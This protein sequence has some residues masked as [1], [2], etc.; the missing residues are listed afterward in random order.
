MEEKRK[1]E[2]EERLLEVEGLVDLL[3]KEPGPFKGW[4]PAVLPLLSRPLLQVVGGWW[5]A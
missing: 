3:Q 1:T 5:L 2:E 4:D